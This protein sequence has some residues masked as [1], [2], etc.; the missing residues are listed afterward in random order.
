MLVKT[1]L[2]C[3]AMCFLSNTDNNTTQKELK[4]FITKLAA[5]AFCRKWGFGD[6]RSGERTILTVTSPHETTLQKTLEKVGFELLKGDFQRRY[7]YPEGDL[8]LYSY[9]F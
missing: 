8:C 5:E 2:P 6:R 9:N 4:E 7:G 1:Q 3:C